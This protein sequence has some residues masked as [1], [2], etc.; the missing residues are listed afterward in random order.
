MQKITQIS[1]ADVGRIAVSEDGHYRIRVEGIVDS[2]RKA[3]VT[4]LKNNP[5]KNNTSKGFVLVGGARDMFWEDEMNEEVKK[6]TT[7]FEIWCDVNSYDPK[8]EF[9]YTNDTDENEVCGF[10]KK[11]DILTLESDDKTICPAFCNQEEVVAYEYFDFNGVILKQ[12][13]KSKPR[14]HKP[15]KKPPVRKKTDVVV[16][17][18]TGESYTIKNVDSVTINNTFSELS[19]TKVIEK[20][21][22]TQLSQVIEKHLISALVIK[23]P[24]GH[25]V[26]TN[27]N[28]DWVIN[29]DMSCGVCSQWC[30]NG[31]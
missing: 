6:P 13:G 17:Y 1:E 14:F 18:K 28:N 26:A 23:T 5:H 25:I 31:L 4:H 15:R 29:S 7:P 10:F 11:G 9:V 8:G 30:F 2:F 20:G 16:H 3:Q 12:K 27:C 22:R 21:I 24:K 19:S